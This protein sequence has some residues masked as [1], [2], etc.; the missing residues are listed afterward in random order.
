MKAG[1]TD[2]SGYPPH[3][4]EDVGEVKG[5]KGVWVGIYPTCYIPNPSKCIKP[6]GYAPAWI[7]LILLAS[8]PLP[9]LLG[10]L[11]LPPPPSMH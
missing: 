7:T 8:L 2:I 11:A 6:Y 5:H 10:T 3:S 9:L 4:G 1:R